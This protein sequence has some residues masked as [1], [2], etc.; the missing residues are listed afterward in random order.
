NVSFYIDPASHRANL[1]VRDAAGN[2]V[3]AT[4]TRTINDGAWHHIAGLR[5][6]TTALIYVDGVEE[7]SASN[8]SLGSV[9]T[10]CGTAFIGAG[11]SIAVCPTTAVENFFNGFIDEVELVKGRALSASEIQAIY[12]AG[13]AGKCRPTPTP[14]PTPTPRPTPVP[15]GGSCYEFVE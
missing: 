4:G 2:S 3:S 8:Q 11:N 9:D 7:G 13:S 14:T 12:N 10:N 6:G 15:F 5:Q 1:F